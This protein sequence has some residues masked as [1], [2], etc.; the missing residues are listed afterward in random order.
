MIDVSIA[1][2]LEVITIMEL[3]S[4]KE[5]IGAFGFYIHIQVKTYRNIVDI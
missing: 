3:F 4:G 2:N 1:H 5:S